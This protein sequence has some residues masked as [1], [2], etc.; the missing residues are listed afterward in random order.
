MRRVIL[1]EEEVNNARDF[2]FE[3]IRKGKKGTFENYFIGTLG[4]IAYAKH[5][6]R[7]VNLEVYER[8]KG[9]NGADFKDVQVKTTTW[10]GSNKQLKVSNNDRCLTN[11]DVTKLVLAHVVLTNPTEV[12]LVGEI[13]KE[14]FLMHRSSSYR[15]SKWDYWTIDEEEL[16]DV[17][18]GS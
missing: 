11:P 8:R 5:T 1:T 18:K 13:S 6:G 10:T 16:Y 15:G 3:L 4:E 12:F 9:D 2:A 14:V 17:E 7:K